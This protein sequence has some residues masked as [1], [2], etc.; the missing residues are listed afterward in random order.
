MFETC[1]C[2]LR[3]PSSL[4]LIGKLTCTAAGSISLDYRLPLDACGFDFLQSLLACFHRYVLI[5]PLNDILDAVYTKPLD[6]VSDICF[7]FFY[8]D[9]AKKNVGARIL[10]GIFGFWFFSV[11]P[12]FAIHSTRFCVTFTLFFWFVF[13]CIFFKLHKDV[14]VWQSQPTVSHFFFHISLFTFGASP[15]F[16]L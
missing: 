13:F 3:F 12:V 6:L 9:K 5:I 1:C 7:R 15:V 8:D 4:S 14:L 16:P 2:S 11:A 10:T